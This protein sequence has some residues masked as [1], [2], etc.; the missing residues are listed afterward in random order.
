MLCLRC[1]P[2]LRLFVVATPSYCGI[3]WVDL[4]WRWVPLLW[5]C[6][7]SCE[8]TWKTR[9]RS[10]AP[11]SLCV[12]PSIARRAAP[13]CESTVGTATVGTATAGIAQAKV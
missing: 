4:P 3:L 12:S 7:L 1:L 2:L 11:R 6:L 10:R 5:L 8:H 9:S 13:R